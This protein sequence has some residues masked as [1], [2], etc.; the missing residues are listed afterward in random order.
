MISQLT[1]PGMAV[2][3]GGGA[4][5]ALQLLTVGSIMRVREQQSGG[6]RSGAGR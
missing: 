3:G 5:C 6:P 2:P 4:R 1:V